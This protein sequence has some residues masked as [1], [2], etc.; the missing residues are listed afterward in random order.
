MFIYTII[1]LILLFSPN[2]ATY[3][4]S[5]ES[6]CPIVAYVV[7]TP[8]THLNKYMCQVDYSHKGGRWII[9]FIF[10]KLPQVSRQIMK[11]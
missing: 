10:F 11:L 2:I 1:L 8:P 9:K 6:S 7:A 5:A 3:Q 4:E